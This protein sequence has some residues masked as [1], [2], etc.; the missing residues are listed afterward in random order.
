MKHCS[1]FCTVICSIKKDN[2]NFQ[3]RITKRQDNYNCMT[4][5][6]EQAHLWVTRAS[7]LRAKRSG[8]QESGAEAPRYSRDTASPLSVAVSP[9]ARVTQR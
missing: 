2:F 6:C 8:G 7:D 3:T 4:P 9:R 5:A 1:C